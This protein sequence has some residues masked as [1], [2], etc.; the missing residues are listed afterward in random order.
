MHTRLEPSRAVSTV[1]PQQ[2]VL[3]DDSSSSCLRLRLLGRLSFYATSGERLCFSTVRSK[4]V[5]A[6]V[7]CT[8]TVN[9]NDPFANCQETQG[10]FRLVGVFAGISNGSNCAFIIFQINVKSSY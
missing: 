1:E 6:F 9:T 3:N 10:F 4:D 7:V 5:L 8:A 2:K